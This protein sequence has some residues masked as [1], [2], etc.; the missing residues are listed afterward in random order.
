MGIPGDSNPVRPERSEAQPSEVEGRKFMAGGLLK[1]APFDF[2]PL[3]GATLRTNGLW[4][5]D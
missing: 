2:A 1:L 3:R 5:I 4:T